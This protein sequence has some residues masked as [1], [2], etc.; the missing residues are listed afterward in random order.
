LYRILAQVP[1]KN[2]IF[3][4][5]C[6]QGGNRTISLPDIFKNTF[7]YLVH[8]VTIIFKISAVFD[9]VVARSLHLRETGHAFDVEA[10]G[11]SNAM[12]KTH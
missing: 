2:N 1:L 11:Q 6:N 10:Q 4:Q 9:P 3:T 5:G 7:S 8:Q 12:T